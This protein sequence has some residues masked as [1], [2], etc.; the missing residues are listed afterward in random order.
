MVLQQIGDFGGECAI[1]RYWDGWWCCCA[2]NVR[3]KERKSWK[4]SNFVEP[5]RV[6]EPL[7]HGRAGDDVREAVANLA[8]GMGNKPHIAGNG[9]VV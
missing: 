4:G 5:T 2:A 7:I 8:H 9:R 3:D 1:N 6:I